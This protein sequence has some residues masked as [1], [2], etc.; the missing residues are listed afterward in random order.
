MADIQAY[1]LQLF[2]HSWATI[3]VQTETRLFFDMSQRNQIRPLPAAGRAAAERTQT[4]RAD[5][6]HMAHPTNGEGKLVLFDKLKPH[7]F[8]LS[9]GPMAF[10]PSLAREEHRGL[11]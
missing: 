2:S 7:G 4:T 11:F 1:L 9:L 5:V 3:T 6:H 10:M 8:G